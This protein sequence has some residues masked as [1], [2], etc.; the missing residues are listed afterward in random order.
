MISLSATRIDADPD[1]RNLH[2]ARRNC[3]F[4]DETENLTIHRSLFDLILV[5]VAGLNKLVCFIP[6]SFFQYLMIRS[7]AN[8]IKLFMSLIY[9]F[10]Y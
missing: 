4:G 9:G 2:P 8:V 10:S 6:A 7:G 3:R 5:D 1:I